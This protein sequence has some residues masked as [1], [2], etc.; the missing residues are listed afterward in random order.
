LQKQAFCSTGF[1]RHI[2]QAEAAEKPGHRYRLRGEITWP[3]R[4]LSPALVRPASARQQC[5]I[6][7]VKLRCTKK[8]EDK[9]KTETAKR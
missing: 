4:K 9:D 8:V 7:H 5:R 6:Y 2:P 3:M 1:P